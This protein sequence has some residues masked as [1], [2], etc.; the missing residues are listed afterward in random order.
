[1]TGTVR[2]STVF[3]TD[4]GSVLHTDDGTIVRMDASSVVRTDDSSVLRKE[5]GGSHHLYHEPCGCWRVWNPSVTVNRGS[6]NK[7]PSISL[8][9]PQIIWIVNTG[10]PFSKVQH[11]NHHS[12]RTRCGC[13]IQTGT[14]NRGS[15]NKY[16]SIGLTGPQIIWMVNTEVPFSQDP[17]GD[18]G[19]Q[20]G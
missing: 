9:G 17:F 14:M 13:G 16:L 2:E 8:K 18:S 10:V 11:R 3:P 7:Y 15:T 1:M 5:D 19:T 6:T 12:Y 4:H 20:P